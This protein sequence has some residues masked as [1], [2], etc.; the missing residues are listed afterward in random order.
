MSSRGDAETNKLKGNIEDQLNRLLT[1]LSDLEEMKDELDNDE[2]EQT[3]QETMD[4][5]KEFELSLQK[6]L[7]GNITLVSDIGS[8][9]LRIQDAIRE[10]F[11]S[12]E[13][14]KM[15]V[16][17]ENGALRRK[18][19]SLV[20]DKKLGRISIDQY[21]VLSSEIVVALDKLGEELTSQEKE[22]LEKRTKDMG[23]FRNANEQI[24][25]H[26]FATA[27]KQLNIKP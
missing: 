20:E 15:F 8:V 7:E 22:M 4:Q 9:Q 21:E 19:A 18:L 1:Q 16:K 14:T 23:R 6:L 24:G 11:K 2:Y 27:Q 10:A 12:P 5:L 25:D 3:R 13:V 26:V 17:K